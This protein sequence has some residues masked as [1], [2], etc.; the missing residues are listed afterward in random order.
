MSRER[1]SALL[2]LV[3]TSLLERRGLRRRNRADHHGVGGAR[4]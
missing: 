1:R 4:D 3:R 2:L